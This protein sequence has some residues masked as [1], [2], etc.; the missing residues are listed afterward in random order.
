MSNASD[1]VIENGVLTR[2]TGPGGAVVIPDSVTAIGEFAFSGCRNLTSVTIPEG[3]TAIGKT[4]FGW[5]HSLSSV[6]IPQSVTTIGDEAFIFCD[7]LKSVTIPEGVTA[8]GKKTFYCCYNLLS[9]NISESVTSIGNNAFYGCRSLKKVVI[10]EGVATIGD[11]TFSA[12]ERLTSVTIPESVTTIGNGAFRDCSSLSIAVIPEGVTTIGDWAFFHCERLTSVTIPESVTTIG[13]RAFDCSKRITKFSRLNPSCKL[14]K[15]V[16]GSELPKGLREGI[17][18]LWPNFTD[19]QLKQYVLCQPVWKSLAPEVKAEIFLTRQGK[20]LLSAYSTLLGAEEAAPIGAMLLKILSGKPSAKDCNVAANFMMACVD[21]AAPDL[22]QEL[23]K[24]LKELKAAEKVLKTIGEN[25]SLT[26]KLGGKVDVDETLPEAEKKVMQFLLEKK[27]NAKDLEKTLKSFYGITFSNLPELQNADGVK[28]DAVVLACLLVMHEE[29]QTPYWGGQ[30]DVVAGYIQPGLSPK[31]QEILALIDGESLKK[32]MIELADA[33]L[34]LTGRSKK[35]FLAYPICRYAD[36]STMAEL[37]KRAPGWRSSVSG[38]DAPPLA[39]FRKA[40]MYSQ[41]RAAM[42]FAEK[43]HELD[44]YAKIRGTT[45]DVIRDR[46]LSD[47]GLDKNGQRSYDLGNQTVTAV[48]QKDLSFLIELSDG[49]TAK[50]LPKKG[51]DEEMYKIASADFSEMKKAVKRIAKSRGN[52]LFEDFLTGR[53]RAAESWKEAYL[54]NPVL[55]MTAK[56]LVWTQKNNTFTLSADGAITSDGT[57]YTISASPIKIAHPME[58]KEKDLAAWQKYFTSHGLKQ[59][60]EQIWEPDRDPEQITKDRYNGAKV[61]VFRFMN[62]E[63]HGIHFYDENFHN[64][65]GF[66]LESCDLRYERTEWHRHEIW[67]DETFTLGEFT[68]SKYTRQVNHIVALLDKWT[69]LERVAKDDITVA[70]FLPGSTLAQITEFIK[71]ASENNATN[72]MA[73]LLDY[74]QKHF[75]D[76]DP[77]EEF[78]LE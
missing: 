4:A 13:E 24:K 41:T 42:L 55:R 47:V 70:D 77:M 38:I 76:F 27:E 64:E 7:S 21:T 51:A 28:L 46:Y 19:G 12:C 26:E 40:N 54:T 44:F 39:T 33:N 34:G 73:I 61:S 37:T 49:K 63:K 35:M 23:Y 71:V 48:L 50:S 58:M 32:T 59:P 57:E 16:F 29:L 9:V 72:V 62:A 68:F 14:G 66:S 74:K 3:V 75:A 6:V 78:T 2:Y 69:V 65:I 22:L 15:D 56:L 31:A 20:P 53:A 5:H 11:G 45:E 18:E 52:V 1:F 30:P 25:V 17:P 8:I 60:F 10:P 43:Y 36:E 67:N